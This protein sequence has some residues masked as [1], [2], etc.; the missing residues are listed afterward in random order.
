MDESEPLLSLE[1]VT[2][3]Q[4]NFREKFPH[5]NKGTVAL[6]SHFILLYSFPIALTFFFLFPFLFSSFLSSFLPSF[7][8]SL[9][10]SFFPSF[11]F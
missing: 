9:P 11:L 10:P 4:W 6:T 3:G 1:L 2:P 8:P 5:E 7:F